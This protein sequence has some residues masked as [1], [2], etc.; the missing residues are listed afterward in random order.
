MSLSPCPYAFEIVQFFHP[1]FQFV[2]CLKI[3]KL[4]WRH[5]Q[6]ASRFAENNKFVAHTLQH[7][8]NSRRNTQI[9]IIIMRLHIT[10]Q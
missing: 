8:M 7:E 3:A 6:I 2:L 4:I 1:L 9:V 10:E 5:L